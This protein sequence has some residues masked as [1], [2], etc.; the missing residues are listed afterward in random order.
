MEVDNTQQLQQLQQENHT[1]KR[2]SDEGLE[3]PIDKKNKKNNTTSISPL[4]KDMNLS[5]FSNLEEFQVF[6]IE[7]LPWEIL[8]EEEMIFLGNNWSKLQI[9]Q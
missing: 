3:N 7:G 1:R 5:L 4:L 9:R 2:G 8:A 6:P